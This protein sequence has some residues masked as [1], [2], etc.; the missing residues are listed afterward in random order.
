MTQEEVASK[1]GIERSTY[2][3]AENGKTVSVITAKKIA[4]VSNCEWVLFF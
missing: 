2:T 1:A 3:N 4:K